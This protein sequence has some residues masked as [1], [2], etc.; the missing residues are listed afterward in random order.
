MTHDL[1]GST[2]LGDCHCVVGYVDSDQGCAVCQLNNYFDVQTKTCNSCPA[3]TTAPP[4]S[5]GVTACVCNSALN[6]TGPA[7]GPCIHSPATVRRN[8]TSR[9]RLGGAARRVY[10]ITTTHVVVIFFGF[11]LLWFTILLLCFEPPPMTAAQIEALP[12]AQLD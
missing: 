1:T 11:G 8:L 4:G 3:Q 10:Y 12:T 6:L 9:Y 2:N 5:V 7:G